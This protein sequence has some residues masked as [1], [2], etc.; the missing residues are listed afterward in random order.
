MQPLW[1]SYP[2]RDSLLSVRVFR[3]HRKF[4][5]SPPLPPHKY[6]S[7]ALQDPSPIRLSKKSA[8]GRKKGREMKRSRRSWRSSP[9]RESPRGSQLCGIPNAGN[10]PRASIS[11]FFFSPLISRFSLFCY[12]HFENPD[13]SQARSFEILGLKL[14]RINSL[15][16]LHNFSNISARLFVLSRHSSDTWYLYLKILY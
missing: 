11:Q 14:V 13:D 5:L 2:V 7:C 10:L 16:C 12:S 3:D 9:R 1:C 6:I 8:R 15:V 4:Y